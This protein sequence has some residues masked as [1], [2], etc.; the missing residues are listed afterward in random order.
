MTEPKNILI[1]KLSSIGDVVHALPFLEALKKCYPDSCIDW[2][3]EEEASR[4]ISGH[5]AV[6]RIIIS[7][8]KRWQKEILNPLDFLKISSEAIRFYRE[9]R[10]SSYDI[11]IDLQGLFRSGFLTALSRGKRKIGMSGAREGASFFL[12]EPPVAVDYD[13]HA[14]DRYL[15][16]AGQLGCNTDIRKG[17]IPVSGQDKKL[18]DGIFSSLSGVET[19]IAVNPMAKW[20]TKLW[21]PDK[22][23]RLAEKLQKETDCRIIFTGSMQDRPVIEEIIKQAGGKQDEIINLAGRTSLKELA[24]L[25][26]GCSV[27]ICTDT[28]PMHIAAAMGCR[29]VALFGPT[30][31]LRTGPYG[32]GHIIIR[33]GIDCS[34]CLKKECGN[35]KCMEDITVDAVFDAVRDI[36]ESGVKD[37]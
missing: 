36:I 12:K 3:V 19:I 35:T 34:P 8:R 24:Y 33:S 20:K 1:I 22:F 13:Q 29:V 6:N 32:N 4:V 25:Y 28:G 14:I 2:L 9:L 31:P 21:Q 23:S 37:Q 18:A 10:L 11:V 26:S 15:E 17:E 5:P 7:G 30:S 16:V 27:L